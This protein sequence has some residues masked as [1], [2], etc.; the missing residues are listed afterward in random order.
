[1]KKECIGGA[2]INCESMLTSKKKEIAKNCNL[3]NSAAV[4]SPLFKKPFEN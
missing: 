1:M 3:F 4:S 2:F